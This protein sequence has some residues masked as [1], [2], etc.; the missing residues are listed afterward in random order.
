MEMYY[1]SEKNSLILIA[2]LKSHKINKVV[3]SPGTTN[4]RLVASLQR[5]SFFTLYSSVD[6]RSA[7]YMACGL[8]AEY[9]EP[10]MLSCTG[11]TA[12]RNYMPALTEAYYRKLPILCVTSSQ[13][14]E[15]IGHLKDQVTNRID[16]PKDIALQSV[17]VNEVTNDRE[18]WN[19]MI[20]INKA[21]L[22]LK[23]RGGGP[24]HINLI[25]SYSRDFSIKEL[26]TVRKIERISYT[27]AFPILPQGELG[28]I[29]GSH[30]QWSE[31]EIMALDAFCEKH[32]AVVF[33]DHT[34]GYYGKYRVQHQLVKLQSGRIPRKIRLL[35]HIGEVS[36]DHFHMGG[37]AEEVWRVSE[38]GEIR[39]T[40]KKLSHVFEMSERY[41]FM[42][43]ASCSSSSLQDQLQSYINEYDDIYSR[44]PEL[45]FSN[46]WIAKVTA[47][48]LPINSVLHLGILT[49]L[50]SWN[51]FKLP[52]LV[53]SYSNVG[54]FGIDGNMSSL[55]GASLAHPEK[56]YLGVVGDLSFFYDMNSLGNRHIGRNLRILLVNNGMG[57]EFT[58][59]MNMG[60]M[61]GEEAFSYVC[62]AGHFGNKSDLLV[63]HYAEDLGFDYFSVSSKEKYMEI[64]DHFLSMDNNKSIIL[65][66]FTNDIDENEALKIA[67]MVKVS[68]QEVVKDI[69]KDVFGNKVW[70]AVKKVVK[71]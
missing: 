31:N 6:E 41:F 8:A 7:A 12:S 64:L 24:S 25:T 5:D 63:R 20:N 51:F 53:M 18:E 10:V 58:H 9:N 30:K 45:P 13:Y 32:N 50:R 65:E 38:D 56:L 2:L 47:G 27:D 46:L 28:V 15:L 67:T 62:A 55:I 16:L 54:G 42:H 21:V 33:C 4:L 43:Y 34:S 39:D 26:P 1:T 17:Q 3:V 52:S 23:R 60:S 59:H 29:V 19:A 14:S 49:S 69:I 70:E 68:T 11:A 48:K 37:D 66:V 22:E 36:G 44:L 57:C 61:L 40:Y 71:K 35:V